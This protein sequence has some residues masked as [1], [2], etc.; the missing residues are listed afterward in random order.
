MQQKDAFRRH[1]WDLLEVTEDSETGKVQWDWVDIF[2]LVLILLNVG[3]VIVETLPG[4]SLEQKRVL[5]VFD[6]FSV[7]VFT[8]EYIA[9][10]WSCTVDPRYADPFRGRLRYARSFYGIVDVLAI[11]PFYI[12]LWLLGSAGPITLV[13]LLTSQKYD[14]RFLRILRLM[15]FARVFKIGRYTEAVDRLK[16]VFNAR[17]SDLGVALIGLVIILILASS[18]MYY[19]ENDDQ[20][21]TFS[22]I[23]ASMWWGMNTLTTVG[24]GDVRP[25]TNGGKLLGGLIQLVGIAFFALP[26][27]ILA[28]GYEDEAR[29]KREA[30]SGLCPTCGRPIRNE[31][32]GSEVA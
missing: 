2:L 26:A 14:L 4:L 7:A 16:A 22:S 32:H 13:G 5:A 23:P 27:G 10:I 20:P 6:V 8:V 1:V 25:S 24:Y 17:K 3:A 9:R 29:R 31:D 21:E 12:G 19:V 11:A 18:A 30:K 28:A 15:R